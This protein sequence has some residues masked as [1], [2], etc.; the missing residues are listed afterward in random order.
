MRVGGHFF[1][2]ADLRARGWSKHRIAKAFA[3]GRLFKLERGLYSKEPPSGNTYLRAYARAHPELV[4]TGRTAASV[5]FDRP[6]ELPIEAEAPCGKLVGRGYDNLIVVKSRSLSSKTFRGVP[7]ATALGAA[8]WLARSSIDEAAAFLADFYSGPRGVALLDQH[9]GEKNRITGPLREALAIASA[10]SDSKA[11]QQLFGA[12]RKAG[13]RVEQNVV[14]GKYRFGGQIKG[15]KILLELDSYNHHSAENKSTFVQDRWKANYGAWR[16]YVVLRYS[17]GC[18]YHH[19]KIV[20]AQIQAMV[21]A[22]DEQWFEQEPVW[23]W[24]RAV[25]MWA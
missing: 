13:L 22:S 25:E 20:V 19:L 24:H 5:Y 4:F 15:T 16:G 12:L 17:G 7:V 2:T 9:L 6:V 3:E 11:E 23:R 18:V 8:T 14:V 1:R 10:G 21:D